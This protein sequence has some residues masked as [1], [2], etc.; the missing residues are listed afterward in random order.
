MRYIWITLAST[1]YA[2]ITT[3]WAEVFAVSRSGKLSSNRPVVDIGLRG[4]N[5]DRSAKL[6]LMEDGVLMGP[7]PYSAPA[8]YYFPLTTRMTAVEVFK[9]PAS[10]RYGPNTI[11]GAINLRVK[12]RQH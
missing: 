4:A 6:T 3:P 11:G 12:V 8:A 1:L 10:I 9:G 2:S 5:P 7:A